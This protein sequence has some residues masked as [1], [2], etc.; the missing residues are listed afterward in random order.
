MNQ[1]PKGIHLPIYSLLVN[2]YKR[3]FL[4]E[5]II[6]VCLGIG[7]KIEIFAFIITTIFSTFLIDTSLVVHPTD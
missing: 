2:I 3:N 5:S 4:M 1:L 7:I 6:I